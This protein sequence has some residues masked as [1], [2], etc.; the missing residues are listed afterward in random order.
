M[1][2]NANTKADEAAIEHDCTSHTNTTKMLRQGGASVEARTSVARAGTIS[3][4]VHFSDDE[5]MPAVTATARASSCDS[6]WPCS[7]QV[8]KWLIS[9]SRQSSCARQR[10]ASE[11]MYR[12]TNTKAD[13]A[14]IEHDW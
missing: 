12:N 4:A 7:E 9:F 5:M 6:M 2:R 8:T 3:S 11:L 10:I 13:E 1:H 14:A